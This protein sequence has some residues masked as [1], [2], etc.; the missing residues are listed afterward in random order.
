GLVG[1]RY[2]GRHPIVPLA[3]T[4]ADLNLEQVG[5]TDATNGPQVGT[6]S[7]TGFDFSDVTK[8]L[9][10]AGKVAGVKV[11][12]DDE[13]SDAYFGRSDNQALADVGIPAHTL[14]VAFN[15]PDYHGVG[16]H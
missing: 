4:I 1:S 15:Y 8:V 2:Y 16:D 5:R 6:A 14:C 10:D 7:I 3:K 12:K 13:A 9:V 11:Y